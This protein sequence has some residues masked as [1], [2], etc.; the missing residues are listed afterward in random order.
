MS[1]LAR[2]GRIILFIL[3]G[4]LSLGKPHL[5][6]LLLV[7]SHTGNHKERYDARFNFGALPCKEYIFYSLYRGCCRGERG[8]RRVILILSVFSVST[9]SSSRI[10]LTGS[11]EEFFNI[12]KRVAGIIIKLNLRYKLIMLQ[13]NASAST[14]ID[15]DVENFNEDMKVTMKKPEIRFSVVKGEFDAKVGTK[16]VELQFLIFE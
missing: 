8:L 11:I 9:F 6:L 2:R 5:K 4:L 7:I 3:S 10:K 14:Y 16:N 13:A 15:S 1:L 12:N